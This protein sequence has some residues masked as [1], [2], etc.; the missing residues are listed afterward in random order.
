MT[1]PSLLWMIVESLFIVNELFNPSRVQKNG[2]SGGK[3]PVTEIRS[4]GVWSGI[5][6]ASIY[7]PSDKPAKDEFM[8]LRLGKMQKICI[9]IRPILLAAKLY[10]PNKSARQKA[11]SVRTLYNQVLGK[12]SLADK[13][14]VKNHP[15][16]SCLL[17]WVSEYVG[18][19]KTYPA[20]TLRYCKRRYAILG[21]KACMAQSVARIGKIDKTNYPPGR[22]MQPKPLMTSNTGPFGAV[23]GACLGFISHTNN[24]FVACVLP[25]HWPRTRQAHVLSTQYG[26]KPRLVQL[27]LN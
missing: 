6:T 7:E 4:Q 16:S 21:L 2:I 13:I 14:F 20:C 11:D 15:P 22:Y 3:H 1:T 9:N 5:Q 27:L 23:R 8:R 17:Q 10:A 18:V 19:S 25:W 12:A 26:K 24:Y